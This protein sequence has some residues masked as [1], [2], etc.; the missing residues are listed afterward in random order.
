MQKLSE[1]KINIGAHSISKKGDVITVRRGY[2]Y[3][4]GKTLNDFKGKVLKAYPNAEIIS[5][6]DHY[7]SFRGGAPLHQQS[8][9]WVKF[10]LP[11]V[12]L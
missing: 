11:E 6:G 10:K 2:Y 12:T 4:F 3:T 1:I 7:A 9:W 5:S 8:H